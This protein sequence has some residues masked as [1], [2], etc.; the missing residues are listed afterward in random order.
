MTFY[1]HST[2]SECP[3]LAMAHYQKITNE[4]C[5][6]NPPT[7]SPPLLY[8]SISLH[9][10]VCA[11]LYQ[12]MNASLP[13]HSFVLYIGDIETISCYM[14]SVLSPPRTSPASPG[15]TGALWAGSRGTTGPLE[16]PHPFSHG[17]VQRGECRWLRSLH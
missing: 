3:P 16:A 11:S 2:T 5:F 17:H 12:S 8:V 1:K 7:T 4:C 9:G 6:L 15:R 14:L 13:L 10:C